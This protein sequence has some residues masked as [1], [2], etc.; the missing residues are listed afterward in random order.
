MKREKLILGILIIA[1]V[2]P[3][4]C[5]GRRISIGFSKLLNNRIVYLKPSDYP[6][7]RNNSPQPIH[8]PV[9][10]KR[11]SKRN[12]FRKNRKRYKR[13]K[14]PKLDIQESESKILRVP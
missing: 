1:S 3:M 13:Y 10:S 12:K 8:T 9:K 6:K 11:S 5:E 2:L 4:I 7:R 14:V